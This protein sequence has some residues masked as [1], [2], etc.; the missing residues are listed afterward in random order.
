[1]KTLTVIKYVFA[2]IGAGMLIGALVAYSHA[3]SFVAHAIH[4]EGTVVALEPRVDTRH[5]SNNNTYT[6]G[7]VTW[8]PRVRFSHDGQAI[9]FIGSTSSNPPSYHVNE[10]VPIL[11][12]ESN[13]YGAKLDTF[14][15]VWIAPLILGLIGAVFFLT[16]ALMIGISRSQARTADRLRHEGVAV[17]ADLQGV[18]MNTS[19]SV[20]GRNPFRITAQWQ[21][22]STS[23]VY[24]FVS[25]NIWFDPS[26]YV[27]GKNI[28]VY[29][30]PGNPKRYYVD[31]SFLP[32]LAN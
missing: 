17:D 19:V 4:A 15:S 9:E 25:H 18:N 28:R 10:T 29:I 7:S 11:F 30:A 1:M 22:P 3:R 5:D 31:L 23:R 8:A 27:T 26:K 24:V 12:E 14:F 16:G 21:D 6:N 20:N 32:E 13:P 2:L